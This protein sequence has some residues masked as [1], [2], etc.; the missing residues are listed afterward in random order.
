MFAYVCV[1]VSSVRKVLKSNESLCCD[2]RQPTADRRQQASSERPRTSRGRERR[3]RCHTKTRPVKR[4][5]IPGTQHLRDV[6]LDAPIFL[7]CST[8][9]TLF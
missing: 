3:G 8:Y 9:E 5:H 2:S 4:S 7:G 1:G 6:V